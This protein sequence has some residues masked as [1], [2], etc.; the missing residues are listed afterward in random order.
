MT[1]TQTRRPVERPSWN[2]ATRDLLTPAALAFLKALHRE[3]EPRRQKLLEARK[4]RQ[5]ALDSGVRPGFQ[6]ETADIRAREWQV[7]APPKD[8]ECRQVEIVG[9]VD[10]RTIV[11]SLNSG[12]DC[13]VA[14]FGDSLSPTWPNVIRGHHNLY[15][16]IRRQIDFIADDGRPFRLSFNLATLIVR[17]RG[18]HLEE[19]RV[20]VGGHPISASLFD[21]GLH[22]FHNARE[23]L[24]RD[25]GPYFSLPKLQNRHEARLWNDVFEFAERRLEIPHGSMRA[26]VVVEHILAAFEME[27]ILHELQDHVTA[28]SAGRWNYVFS[29]I[30]TFGRYPELTLPDRNDVTMTVPFM[31]AFTELLIRTCHRRG[32]HAIGTASAFVPRT[33]DPELRDRAID[34]VRSEMERESHDGFDGTSVAHRGLVPLARAAFV[35]VL[36]A[37]PHH[38]NHYREDVRVGAY[39]LIALADTGGRITRVG[40]ALNVS[41]ALQYMTCWLRG[42][43]SIPIYH[44]IEDAST[45]EISRAQLWQWVRHGVP[46]EDGTPVTPDLYREI[47]EREQRRLTGRLGDD[48][49][50]L[51]AAARWLDAL[52]LGDACPPFMAQ[53][54]LKR[55]A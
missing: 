52:V 23:L 39:D 27:E 13:F 38:K 12:A 9:P 19:A 18:W 5:T 33:D 44:A 37:S 29:A 1:R 28:L 20:K 30:K 36:G 53:A 41:V 45:A 50:R 22:A 16:A 49:G 34:A 6:P 55:P 14:D 3:F 2:D 21:F 25:S 15:D 26:T 32:A 8:L 40:M 48:D 31:R 4:L 35:S 24:E 54:R 43:G 10:R 17:P 11:N 42:D 51:T 7:A 46:L 47:R